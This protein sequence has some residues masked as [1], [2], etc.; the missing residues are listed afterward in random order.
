[1]SSKMFEELMSAPDLVR[2]QLS[3]GRE[4][5][6]ELANLIVRYQPQ[7]V[8]TLARGSSD[9]ASNYFAYLTMARIGK[10]VTSLPMS[11]LTIED[12]PL[13]ARGVMAVAFSQSGQS[14]DVIQPIDYFRKKNAL[15]VAI[16]ND[17]T[18]PLANAAQYCV[19]V[20]AGLEKSVAATKS[21]IA[22]MVAG[23]TLVAY[24]QQAQLLD[25]KVVAKNQSLLQSLQV[26]PQA[27]QKASQIDWSSALA[28]VGRIDRLFVV[29]R[30]LG[31]A[32]ALEAA[33]KLKEVCGIQAEAYS[34]AEIKHGPMSLIDKDMVVLVFAPEGAAQAGLIDFAKQMRTKGAQVLLIGPAA[35][36]PDLETISTGN[37]DL[38]PIAM[39]QT[40]YRFV[41]ALSRSLGRDPDRPPL[42]S[43]V[44]MT[45]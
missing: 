34:G 41:E 28:T 6:I 19:P 37:P 33:L 31:L 39:I 27:L 24:W 9:H 36:E 16:V 23:A 5:A 1:M 40:F 10:L 14:P 4:P 20:K 25:S 15:T 8:V 12:A 22:Q 18:S 32:V 2:A 29:G 21:F 30:G 26:L 35:I 3:S 45:L 17:Q 44:T 43:K 38:D 11:L 42:L 7:A 13:D